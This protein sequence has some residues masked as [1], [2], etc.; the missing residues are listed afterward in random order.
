MAGKNLKTK[1]I[2]GTVKS[3]L[4][5]TDTPSICAWIMQK[6]KLYQKMNNVLARKVLDAETIVTTT[7]SG[8]ETTNTTEYGDY[9]V[10]NQTMS[11]EEWVLKPD[12]FEQ[13]YE[14]LEPYEAPWDIYAPLGQVYAIKLT[15]AVLA[16]RQWP[17]DFYIIAAWGSEMICHRG[18]YLVCPPDGSEFYRIDQL[19]F[20]E[21]Y[22][23]IQ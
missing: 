3:L 23:L 20:R 8:V 12:K 6:G 14:Y 15:T 13:K 21:T 18:D 7:S 4:T 5:Q 1:S 19:E 16:N 22:R 10:R 17:D 2:P 11:A 9:V